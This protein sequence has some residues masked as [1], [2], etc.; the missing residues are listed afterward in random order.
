MGGHNAGEV[1]SALAVEMAVRSV[2][3]GLKAGND[4]T[5]VL[6]EAIADANALI[7][8]KSLNNPAWEEMGSTVVMALKGIHQVTIGHVGDSRAYFVRRDEIRQLTNDH[9]FVYE[10]FKAGKITLQ[11]ARTHSQRHGLTE[12]L[13]VT[14]E[15]EGEVAAWPLEDDTCLLLCSDGLTDIL[16]DHEILHIVN[17]SSR[18]QQACQALVSAA[19]TKGGRDD[20]TVILVCC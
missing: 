1:A 18:P 5:L 8:N 12:V 7:F 2:L 3:K 17:T 4:P 10:W 16:E 14:E 9:T 15:V 13:G 6:R 19:K 20:M 11:Q